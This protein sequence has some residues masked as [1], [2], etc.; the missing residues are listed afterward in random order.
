MSLDLSKVAE[1]PAWL[2]SLPLSPTCLLCGSA[3]EIIGLWVPYAGARR[4]VAYRLCWRCTER[5][6]EY[7][8]VIEQT[9]IERL[10]APLN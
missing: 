5:A 8:D 4:L 3:G 9:I 10:L 2:K 1:A 7:G 6:D